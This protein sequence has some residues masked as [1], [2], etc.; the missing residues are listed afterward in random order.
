MLELLVLELLRLAG[1]LLALEL[2]WLALPWL[3]RL[4]LLR[5]LLRLALPLLGWTLLRELLSSLLWG[6]ALPGWPRLVG[7]L[8]PLGRA[9]LSGCATR[10]TVARTLTG[11][12]TLRTSLTRPLLAEPVVAHGGNPFMPSVPLHSH[13]APV[14]AT[15]DHECDRRERSANGRRSSAM[16]LLCHV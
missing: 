15:R 11:P 6:P 7:G 1:M 8:A 12:S 2:L 4:T 10:L 16:L 3:L 9:G 14:Q 5:V 13:I